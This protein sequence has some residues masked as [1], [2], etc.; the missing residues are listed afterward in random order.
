M[1]YCRTPSVL[2]LVALLA[3]ILSA[4]TLPVTT[5]S[6]DSATRETNFKTHLLPLL[7]NYCYDCH[8]SSSEIDLE[9]DDRAASLQ[10]NRS[11]WS[12]AIAHLRLGSMP[13]EDGPEMDAATRDR[14]MRMIDALA[15]AV[16]CVQNPNAGR[17]ALRRLNRTEYQNTIRDLTGVDYQPA[18]D[19]PGDDV[20]YGFDN[21]GDV[22]SLPPLL[23]EKYLD[24][25]L[26]IAGKAIYT[27]PPP[28]L[29]EVERGATSLIG[30]EKF[31]NRTPLV[32]PSN[33]TVALQVDLP[34][35]GMYTLTVTA[36]GDQGGDEPVKIDV[37]CGQ[38]SK[39]IEVPG[40][41]AAE[42]EIPLRLGKG[43]RKIEFSFINDYYEKDV[44]DRN[45]RLHHVKLVGTEN[46]VT[47]VDASL[48]PPS[49]RQILFVTPSKDVDASQATRAV[50]ARFASRAFRRP[51]SPSQVDRLV[52]LADQVRS[53]G[54]T[55]EE[56]IQVAIGAVLV[57]PSFLFKVETPQTPDTDGV[58]PS[59]DDY[60]LATRI[61]YFLWS[62][63]PDD[64]LLLMAHRGTLRDRRLLLGK[65]ASMMKDRRAN[66]FVE[67]FA[68]Q[69]LQIRNLDTV[70]P[71]RR[72][73]RGFDDQIRE[74]MKRETLTFFAGV[75]RE[76]LPVTTLLDADFTYLN[77]P[78]AQFYG[79]AGVEGDAF[80]KV[81]LAGTQRGGLLTHASV[82]TVTSNPTRTSP[83]KRGKWVLENLLNTPPPPAPPNV[84]E[85]DRGQLVGS[86]RQRMEQHRSN[87]ACATCHNMMDPLGFALENFDAVGR[88]RTTD[89]ADEIDASGKFPDGTAFSGVDDLR[90][91]LAGPRKEQFIRCLAEKLLIYATGRGTEYYD[92]CAIDKIVSQCRAHE[93]RFAYLIVAIIESDP[94]QKQGFRE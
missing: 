11:R 81:S 58:M 24:A 75:M 66:Q 87:P 26:Q 23:M 42:F 53:D 5:A 35:G 37:T 9:S 55:F 17:V 31:G 2:L 22:L 71:D 73:Y 90:R 92:K 84:P 72:M 21:I 39:V 6:A 52:A 76:N 48:F 88:W 1:P 63:M 47:R 82:L 94:F 16:D 54:G 69:W 93:D 27:P 91:L 19:F 4:T 74:L 41:D 30:A 15:N 45:L 29:Y 43:E 32:M 80:R 18:A 50:L 38:R 14:M 34:F 3:A 20:G 59:I 51:A 64:E 68:S 13:P 49:H 60:E 40:S 62:S 83:V 86:L 33:G 79:I 10:S 12:Q 8:D 28:Q 78:L 57:S 77:Q 65:I 67:N 70:D 85:L 46:K 25:A 61:S 56:S 89:G 36:S 7:R 44:A